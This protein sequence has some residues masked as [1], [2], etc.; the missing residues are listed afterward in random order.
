MIAHMLLALAFGGM[1]ITANGDMTAADILARSKEASGG[2]RWDRI[3]LLHQTETVTGNFSGTIERWLDLRKGRYVIRIRIGPA[4]FTEGLTE[5]AAWTQDT[6]GQVSLKDTQGQLREARNDAYRGTR[7]YYYPDRW[8][9]RVELAGQQHEKD[10][11]FYVVRVI[12]R[13]GTALELWIDQGT[14]LVDRIVDGTYIERYS[15]YREA[16]GVKLPARVLSN[17]GETEMTSIMQTADGSPVADEALFRLP[18][19][20]PPDFE[21]RSGK[22]STAVPFKFLGNSI[23]IAPRINGKGPF[24]FVLDSGAAN[25]ITPEL[26]RT[27]ALGPQGAVSVTGAGEEKPLAGMVKVERVDMGDFRM[28]DQIFTVFPLPPM[29]RES[30]FD[31]I[32]GYELFRRLVVR[33]DYDRSTL[34][35]AVPGR[36]KYSGS[37]VP[38]AIRFRG[39]IPFVSGELDGLPAQFTI[40]TGNTHALDLARPFWERNRLDKK[41]KARFSTV[42][43]RGIGGLSHGMPVRVGSLR[44][45]A[46]ELPGLIAVLSEQRSGVYAEDYVSGNLGQE[47]LSL[48]N[49]VIDYSRQRIILER[50][51]RKSRLLAYDRSGMALDE[52]GDGIEVVDVVAGGPAA[53]AGIASGNRILAVD[54]EPTTEMSVARLRAKLRQSAGVSVRL[55]VKSDKGAREITLVLRDLL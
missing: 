10:R 50:N 38:V 6:A 49:L 7:G 35:L 4:V 20:P 37:G 26:A 2:V 30:G 46:V 5:E 28:R 36:F 54:G 8:P 15:D 45:G 25:M 42:T 34:Q 17:P 1:A 47:V 43:S 11:R 13:G 22:D 23:H 40:D 55:R 51:L 53:A 39:H 9:A 52:T 24:R 27:L 21:I 31:G 18:A 29:N 41:Y 44:L 48:F 3:E 19:P 32:I 16:A 14:F 33:V 12:P